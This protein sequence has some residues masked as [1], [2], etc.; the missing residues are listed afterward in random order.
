MSEAP[1]VECPECELS[2]KVDESGMCYH[3]GEI[4]PAYVMDELRTWHRED[5]E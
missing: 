3:C 2:T 1:K 5:D 4:L